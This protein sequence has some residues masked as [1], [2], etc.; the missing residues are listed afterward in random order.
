M[1]NPLSENFVFER[2]LINDRISRRLLGKI[3]NE[4]AILV[5]DNAPISD[6]TLKEIKLLSS[7]SSITPKLE[8]TNDDDSFSIQFGDNIEKQ[9]P[10]I[11]N[12]PY[13]TYSIESLIKQTNSKLLLIYP[14]N[15]NHIRKYS[16][17]KFI[18]FDETATIY[19]E[20]TKLMIENLLTIQNPNWNKWIF[21]ILNGISEKESI[22]FKDNHI[23]VIH[24]NIRNDQTNPELFHLLIFPSINLNRYSSNSVRTVRDLNGKEDL[25]WLLIV[26]DIFL[27][28]T[29]P[30]LKP[31][32]SYNS[33]KCYFH[34]LPTYFYLHIHVRHINAPIDSDFAMQIGSSILLEDV[35]ENLNLV[36]D[37]FQRRTIRYAIG[38]QHPFYKE[39]SN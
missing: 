38:E 37:Y 25:N 13:F 27:K 15:E 3:G 2:I 33:M 16:K 36:H 32:L 8:H 30:K 20:K 9:K 12:P 39:L 10:L 19:K 26:R 17:Q 28:N 7:S 14:A 18:F 11:S 6:Q 24:D 1:N 29:L 22:I 4:N 35:I 34:Y 21:D 23:T 31:E 5:I